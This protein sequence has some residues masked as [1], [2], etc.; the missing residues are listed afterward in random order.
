M[1]VYDRGVYEMPADQY[2][3][4]PCEAPSLSSSLIKVL[5]SQSP[6]HAKAKHP[7]LSAQIAEDEAEHYDI[8]TVAHAI[9]LEAAAWFAGESIDQR[10]MARPM[11]IVPRI[12]V[13]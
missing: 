9:L 3:A 12:P 11:V 8:G 7:R 13:R 2:H 4:D 10:T 5:C 6:I 1:T